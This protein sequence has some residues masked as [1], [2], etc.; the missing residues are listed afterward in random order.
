M[1]ASQEPGA[2]ENTSP[3]FLAVGKLRRSHG[4]RGEIIMDIL[5]D[6]PERIRSGSTLYLGTEHQPL[7][8]RSRRKADATLLLA[9]D[10]YDT[11]ETV[12]Q[13]RNKVVYVP[14][15]S[16]PALPE[17][18]YYH[19]QLIGKRVVTEDGRPLGLLTEIIETGAND[20]AVVQPEVGSEILL[21]LIG[22]VLL[23][24]DETAGT[25]QVHLLAGILPDE[26]ES[27][28]DEKAP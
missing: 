16:R 8:V 11:P 3:D 4:V 14:V 10:G 12:G 20:V 26:T 27:A 9:F 1:L 28:D 5:T 17:G 24:V 23:G 7:R 6:F 25:V 2:E 21:P 22:E 18:E 19:H 13:L 15:E